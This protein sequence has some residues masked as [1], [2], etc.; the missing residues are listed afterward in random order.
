MRCV[1][2]FHLFLR[3]KALHRTRQGEMKTRPTFRRNPMPPMNG[4]CSCEKEIA[5]TQSIADRAT[6]IRRRKIEPIRHRTPP[7]G[8]TFERDQPISYTQ[9]TTNVARVTVGVPA[10][11]VDDGLCTMEVALAVEQPEQDQTMIR[12]NVAVA[13]I[14]IVPIMACQFCATRVPILAIH[15][16]PSSNIGD[17]AIDNRID[18]NKSDRRI[19]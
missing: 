3:T 10:A 8:T 1:F 18:R 15:R 14:F 6:A 13:S 11:G 5:L 7:I 16:M 19:D 9:N 4:V 12:D 17:Q 2:Y